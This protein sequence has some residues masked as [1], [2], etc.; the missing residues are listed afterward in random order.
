MS[1]PSLSLTFAEADRPYSIVGVDIHSVCIL[2]ECG[3]RTGGRAGQGW[4][5]SEGLVGETGK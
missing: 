1:S 2:A 4:F 5:G 3:L